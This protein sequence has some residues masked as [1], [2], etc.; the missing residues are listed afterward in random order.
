MNKPCWC[1]EVHGGIATPTL[2]E[3]WRAVWHLLIAELHI[4]ELTAWLARK[5]R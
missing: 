5:L 1:G 2:E 4:P 3:A